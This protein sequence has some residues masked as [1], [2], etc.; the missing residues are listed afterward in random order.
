ML[1]IGGEK[2]GVVQ[3]VGGVRGKEG[4]GSGSEWA[5]EVGGK[6]KEL[7]SNPI[8]TFLIKPP[9]QRKDHK[10]ALLHRVD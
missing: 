8:C 7:R 4:R 1:R 9:E 5:Q 3:E 2:K 6:T 10:Y